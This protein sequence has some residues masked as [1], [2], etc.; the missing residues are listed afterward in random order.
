MIREEIILFSV[1][2]AAIGHDHYHGEGEGAGGVGGGVGGGVVGNTDGSSYHGRIRAPLKSIPL[3]NISKASAR[4]WSFAA[5]SGILG[6]AKFPA[7]SF[8]VMSQRP[9][10]SQYSSRTRSRRLLVKTKIWLERSSSC[11]GPRTSRASPSKLRRKSAGCAA[12]HTLSPRVKIM[13]PVLPHR[14]SPDP[15]PEKSVTS[16]HPA[17]PVPPTALRLRDEPRIIRCRRLAASTLPPPA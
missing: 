12:R 16:L 9:V 11:R 17:A 3:N 1:K 15:R 4:S 6:H 5:P 10:P 13:T 14:L 8:F 2:K 7:S